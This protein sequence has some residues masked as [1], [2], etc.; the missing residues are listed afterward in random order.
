MIKLRR[1]LFLFLLFFPLQLPDFNNLLWVHIHR[2]YRRCLVLLFFCHKRSN[3]SGGGLGRGSCKTGISWRLSKA[4]SKA[5]SWRIVYFINP[6]CVESLA[7]NL[8]VEGPSNDPKLGCQTLGSF[9]HACIIGSLLW[10]SHFNILS[11][12]LFILLL[13]LYN[14]QGQMSFSFLL[15]NPSLFNLFLKVSQ[16]KLSIFAWFFHLG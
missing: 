12:Q 6:S 13:S 5:Q 8:E 9:S 3:W 4:G 15:S 2:R 7:P 11:L 16:S 10:L 14:G 1:G